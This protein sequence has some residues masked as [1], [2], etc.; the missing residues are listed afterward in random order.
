MIL[1]LSIVLFLNHP[2]RQLVQDIFYDNKPN[3]IACDQLPPRQELEQI[4]ID[5]QRLVQH[6][7]QIGVT[8]KTVS[9]IVSEQRCGNGRAEI[10]IQYASHEQREQIE[11]I[12]TQENFGSA[13]VALQNT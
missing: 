13:P 2:I 7:E 6:I 8:T 12:L 3:Y 4:L 10:L 11:A 1:F 5:K 9:V